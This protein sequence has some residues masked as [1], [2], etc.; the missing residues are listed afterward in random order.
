MGNP[1]NIWA[2]G[3]TPN[4]YGKAILYHNGVQDV[5]G[6]LKSVEHLDS[7]SVIHVAVVHDVSHDQAVTVLD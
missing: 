2:R 4:D 5:V 1:R 6:I 7:G 3:L